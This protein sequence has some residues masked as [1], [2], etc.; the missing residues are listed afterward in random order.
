[1]RSSLELPQTPWSSLFQIWW[2]LLFFFTAKLFFFF[3]YSKNLPHMCCFF[4]NSLPPPRPSTSCRQLLFSANLIAVC[5]TSHTAISTE[6][7]T[8]DSKY[9]EKSCRVKFCCQHCVGRYTLIT[10]LQTASEFNS[11]KRHVQCRTWYIFSVCTQFKMYG[12][13]EVQDIFTFLKTFYIDETFYI[14]VTF[15][16][17]SSFPISTPSPA[18]RLPVAKLT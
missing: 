3:V 6:C 8:R 1:M 7:V 4:T 12:G 16:G 17:R 14:Y 2:L 5:R 9:T 11:S 13:Q 10:Q 18:E 15:A